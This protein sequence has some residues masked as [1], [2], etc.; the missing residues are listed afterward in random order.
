MSLNAY[1]EISYICI[2]IL[3]AYIVYRY[4]KPNDF[5]P[6][7]TTASKMNATKQID[8]KLVNIPIIYGLFTI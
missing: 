5:A 8:D 3:N 6:L 4:M 2:E 1:K 7:K